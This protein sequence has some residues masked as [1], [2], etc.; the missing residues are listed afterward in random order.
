MTASTP[1]GRSTRSQAANTGPGSPPG[2][3]PGS[4][5]PPQATA[6][7]AGP[8]AG[9]VRRPAASR[10]DTIYMGFRG[11]F[12]PRPPQKY[13]GGMNYQGILAGK[14]SPGHCGRSLGPLPHA[15][16]LAF[17]SHVPAMYLAGAAQVSA[18]MYL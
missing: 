7:P 3:P 6:R 12:S 10:R 13:P 17:T 1:P 4:S 8:A 11:L 18:L 5:G 15:L 2:S 16:Y 14:I 9:P